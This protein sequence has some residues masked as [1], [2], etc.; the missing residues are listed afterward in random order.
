M[1]YENIANA[2]M[3]SVTQ[4]FQFVSNNVPFAF[5]LILLTIWAI[6]AMTNYNS[7]VKS[8]GYGNFWSSAAVSGL[9]TSVLTIILSL[10]PGVIQPY[11]TIASIGMAVL[12]IVLLFSES[13]E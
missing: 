3:S 11:V 8:R 10:I 4:V 12:S 9:I 7:Q 2:N 13:N 5:P 1:A 6:I